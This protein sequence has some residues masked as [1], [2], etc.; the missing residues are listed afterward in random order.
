[1]DTDI[2]DVTFKDIGNSYKLGMTLM[3]LSILL[4]E[5]TQSRI[6][7]INKYWC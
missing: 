3:V 1:M 6:K 5:G 7:G 4:W 2:I